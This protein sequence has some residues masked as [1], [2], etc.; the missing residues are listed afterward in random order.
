M[1]FS[2]GILL[3]QPVCLSTVRGFYWTY[4][5]NMRKYIIKAKRAGLMEI[6][7]TIF[8]YLVTILEYAS[9]SIIVLGIIFSSI[10]AAAK[11]FKKQDRSKLFDSYRVMVGRCIILGLEILIAA[12]ILRS[13][14]LQ[15]TL[16]SVGLLAV[17][18]LI[19]TF[20]SFSLEV[21]TKGRWPWQKR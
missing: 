19:R 9:A 2:K 7:R 3:F 16:E 10:F 6:S 13:L 11:F 4:V 5:H 12:D 15:F 18:V 1:K 8:T 17:I 14:A 21:E 20:L